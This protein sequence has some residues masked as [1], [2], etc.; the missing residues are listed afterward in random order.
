MISKEE[1]LKNIEEGFQKL[2]KIKSS[3]SSEELK[4]NL[5]RN[6]HFLIFT[7]FIQN[8]LVLNS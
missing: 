7:N 3:Y 5:D 1:A 8:T 6:Y 4:I 2:N